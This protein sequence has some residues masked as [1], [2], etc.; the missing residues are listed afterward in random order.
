MQ[1]DTEGKERTHIISVTHG[2]ISLWSSLVSLPASH[3]V[4]T[5]P[6]RT[7]LHPPLERERERERERDHSPTPSQHSNNYVLIIRL[8]Q[9]LFI[10]G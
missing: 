10:W 2:P 1:T 5:D 7:Q 6:Q 3:L 9:D 4:P 8:I